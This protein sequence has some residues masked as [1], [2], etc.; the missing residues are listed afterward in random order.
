MNEPVLLPFVERD[1]LCLGYRQ[2]SITT[3][4]SMNGCPSRSL[5]DEPL[6]H[7]GRQAAD[8]CMSCWA[9]QQPGWR[10][11]KWG[12]CACVILEFYVLTPILQ[13]CCTV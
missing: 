7:S 1:L 13:G 2:G 8:L 4:Q 3:L 5:C 11:E 10:G 9:Q 12:L 6:H